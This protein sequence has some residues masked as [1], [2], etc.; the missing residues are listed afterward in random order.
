MPWIIE[1]TDE[2]EAWWDTLGEGEQEDVAA[3]VTI[4][5]DKGPQL[6]FPYSSGVEGSRHA[7]MRE[8]RVQSGGDP[9]FSMPSIRAGRRFCSSA[10]TRPA[11]TAS[12]SA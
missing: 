6:P 12:T 1:H 9:L 8:L 10:A 7:H 11:M 2:F 4:L 3:I 5:E